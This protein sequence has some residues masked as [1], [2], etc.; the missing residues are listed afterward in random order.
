[1]PSIGESPDFEKITLY[2]EKIATVNILNT[3][4][5]KTIK[6]MYKNRIRNN[7]FH[8]WL[9]V[10]QT[11]SKSTLLRVLSILLLHPSTNNLCAILLNIRRKFRRISPFNYARPYV[12][13]SVLNTEFGLLWNRLI[14]KK[15]WTKNYYRRLFVLEPYMF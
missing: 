9:T 2:T 11:T 15:C 4:N 5:W 13:L 6:E 3:N 12:C 7:K 8:K 14:N 10:L 1:M